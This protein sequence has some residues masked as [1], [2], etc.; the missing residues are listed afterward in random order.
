MPHALS[1][2]A[3]ELKDLEQQGHYVELISVLKA[4]MTHNKRTFSDPYVK[5]WVGK[6]WRNLF[7]QEAVQD[8]HAVKV[9]TKKIGFGKDKRPAEQKIAERFLKGEQL[10]EWAIAMPAAQATTQLD[11]SLIFCP[12]FIN[13]ILPAH[14]FAEE[15]PL[16]EQEFGWNIFQADAHPMRSCE[17]NEADLLA[18]I[19]EGKG[20]QSNPGGASDQFRTPIAPNDVVLMGYSKGAPDILSTLV[21]HH[22]KLDSKVKCVVT[23]AGAIGGS[24]MADNFYELIKN[25]DTD[26]LTGRLHDFLQ[27]LAPGV[28][29][30]GSLRR[31]NEY[32]I[33]AGV[34]SLTTAARADFYKQ[35]HG[36][37]DDL[38]IPIINITAA[39]TALEVPTFQM[40]DCLNLTRYDGNNDMQVTQEQAKLKIPMA[41]HAAMLHGHHWDISYPPFPRAMRMT[42]PNLDHP[43]PR[44]AAIIAIMKLL[45][46]LGLID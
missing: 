35:Y 18:A 16:L 23:W 2:L 3:K 17:A 36:L 26:L 27:L 43:F 8:K 10:T 29:R 15:F 42:S 14:A 32:D 7:I 4:H 19:L 1:P 39:T 37:L 34:H 28:T 21:N 20:F 9:A 31:L 22:D 24:Y 45:S 13:G 46:E 30:K 38:N 25:L 6:R 44:K 5:E 12:G 40:A 41:T 11:T 33:K